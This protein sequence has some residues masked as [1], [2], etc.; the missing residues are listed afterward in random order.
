MGRDELV[1]ASV[2][3]I[4]AACREKNFPLVVDGDGL[5][6][7]STRPDLIKGYDKAI[8]TPNVVGSIEKADRLCRACSL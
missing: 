8:L 7:L 4:I 6:L 3:S 1:M 5:F 2:A